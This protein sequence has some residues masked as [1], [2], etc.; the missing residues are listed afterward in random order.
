M[1]SEIVYRP[2]EKDSDLK[3]VISIIGDTWHDQIPKGPIRDAEAGYDFAHLYA[4]ST[5]SQVAI[6]DNQLVGIVLARAG[7]PSIKHQDQWKS[8]ARRCLNTE[9]KLSN[10]LYQSYL[11]ELQEEN[12]INQALLQ[13][14][15]PS[16]QPYEAQLL[17][18]SQQAQGHG[19]GSTL[20]SAVKNYFICQQAPDAYLFTDTYCNFLFYDHIG[21]TMIDQHT[22]N[23]TE[24]G[25]LADKYFVY[26][27][28]LTS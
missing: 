8:C 4:Q 9:Q 1:V 24:N 23:N 11:Y 7:A 5:F 18:V 19:V 3:S 14:I 20:I 13:S 10:Q 15:Q 22:V 17:I 2:F 26:G 27:F 25:L 21:L 28:D 16:A 6:L 12:H